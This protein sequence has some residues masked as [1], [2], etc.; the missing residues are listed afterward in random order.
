[1]VEDLTIGQ[2]SGMGYRFV[3]VAV[4]SFS[5]LTAQTSVLMQHNDLSRTG[6]NLSETTLTPANV[7]AANFGKLF[8]VPV[9]GPIYGQPLYV[10]G[11]SIPGQGLHNVVFVTTQHDSVHA[12]DADS[13][14]AP[15]WKASLLDAGH[16]AAA[17]A[18]TQLGTL[19][20]L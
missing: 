16:W 20:V 19:A 1:M 10:P 12:F 11:V 4:L 5:G 8:S 13:N 6:Q 18:W 15:L 3:L 17:G 7:N 14:G 2:T 9:D